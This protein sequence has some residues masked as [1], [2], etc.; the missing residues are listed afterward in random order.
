M[1]HKVTLFVY[2]LCFSTLYYGESRA[3][4]GPL[5]F[6]P[7]AFDAD[8]ESDR[9][10]FT[11]GTQTITPG[12]LQLEGGYTFSYDD[13]GNEEKTGH[14]APELLLRVG[15]HDIIEFRLGWAGYINEETESDGGSETQDGVS[16]L[17]L[18]AKFGL[19]RDELT[20]SVI[21]AM[22]IPSGSEAV[23]AEEVEPE[24]KFL[25]GYDLSS[26]LALG[27]NLNIVWPMLDGDRFTEPQATLALSYDLLNGL[28]A[29]LEYFG[30]YP[31]DAPAGEEDTHYLSPGLTLAVTQDLQLDLRLGVGLND[32]ADD[33]F[34]GVG[35]A[36]RI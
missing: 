35:F 17:N 7:A 30:F 10:D 20:I 6:G 5:G 9:P 28:G 2:F 23:G 26:R 33:F 34:S 27:S 29:Y 18:G 19:L 1:Q 14:V 25:F 3:E 16:D 24:V 11:E 13:S 21:T 8:L 22:T 12:H 36:F 4:S 32:E 15:L 31:V